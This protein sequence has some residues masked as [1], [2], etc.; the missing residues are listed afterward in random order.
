MGWLVAPYLVALLEII[1]PAIMQSRSIDWIGYLIGSGIYLQKANSGEKYEAGSSI[2]ERYAFP[3]DD[4]SQRVQK[5]HRLVWIAQ[6]VHGDPVDMGVD[7]A[8]S[9]GS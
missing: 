4:S 2:S 9:P 1:E 7:E 3:S 5:E 6:E 8:P